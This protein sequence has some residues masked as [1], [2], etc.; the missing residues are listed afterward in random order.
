MTG[1]VILA[2][3]SGPLIISPWD[4]SKKQNFFWYRKICAIL[5]EFRNPLVK[6]GKFKKGPEIAR[7][8]NWADP[9]P[10]VNEILQNDNFNR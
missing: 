3:G 7:K 4:E 9:D 8:I 2:E 10:R 1:R 6:T 5:T